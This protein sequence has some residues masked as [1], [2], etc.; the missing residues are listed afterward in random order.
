MKIYPKLSLADGADFTAPFSKTSL[1]KNDI[2]IFIGIGGAGIDML[3]ALKKQMREC[4]K[5]DYRVDDEP[6]YRNVRFLAVDTDPE[7]KK[8]FSDMEFFCLSK[9]DPGFLPKAMH[10]MPELSWMDLD[11]MPCPANM[12]KNASGCRAY[13]RAMFMLKSAS[14]FD[15][16]RQIV[17]ELYA[18]NPR[19]RM[20]FHIVSSLVGGTGSACLLD[21]C[22]LIRKALQV[23][24][25]ESTATLFGYL[26]LPDAFLC[27]LGIDSK[28][29]LA[30]GYAA[31]KE[32]DYFMQVDENGGQCSVMYQNGLYVDWDR[33]PL[34][35]CILFSGAD[36]SGAPAVNGYRTA[37]SAAVNTALCYLHP[38]ESFGTALISNLAAMST[39][40]YKIHGACT[41]YILVNC[42]A[43]TFPYG[44]ILA[45]LTAGIFRLLDPILSPKEMDH[46]P[47][48]FTKFLDTYL[49]ENLKSAAGTV[50]SYEY[51]AADA[52]SMGVEPLFDAYEY[53]FAD[54]CAKINGTAKALGNQWIER[55]RKLLTAMIYDPEYGPFTV[56]NLFAQ[57]EFSL[58]NR[59]DDRIVYLLAIEKQ[60]NERIDQ[61][62]E[63]IENKKAKLGRFRFGYHLRCLENLLQER[64]AM[65]MEL[66]TVMAELALLPELKERMTEYAN[67]LIFPLA[68]AC[69]RLQSTMLENTDAFRLVMDYEG[70]NMV[71]LSELMLLMEGDIQKIDV[72][73]A[74]MRFIDG[75]LKLNPTDD[76]AVS[77]YLPEFAAD[78]FCDAASLDLTRCLEVKYQ[79][80]QSAVLED[81][82]VKDLYAK[83]NEDA[84]LCG[85]AAG[86]ERIAGNKFEVMYLPNNRPIYA[87]GAVYKNV[88]AP[89]IYIS[90]IKVEHRIS[91]LRY[92]QLPLFALAIAEQ[93]EQ[94]YGRHPQLSP[95]ISHKGASGDFAAL[96]ELLPQRLADY[97][98]HPKIYAAG[99]EAKECLAFLK[100]HERMMHGFETD[101]YIDLPQKEE[102]AE[103]EKVMDAF[104]TEMIGMDDVSM[105][106]KWYEIADR[107]KALS[108]DRRIG[109]LN[110]HGADFR[111]DIAPFLADRLVYSPV[112]FSAIRYTKT[113]FDRYE[114]LK[115]RME[116]VEHKVQLCNAYLTAVISGAIS[117]N[118]LTVSAE[119]ENFGIT[120]EFVLS[121]PAMEFGRF[122]LY[123]GY[124]NFMK[125]KESTQA[126]IVERSHAMLTEDLVLSDTLRIWKSHSA[127][128]HLQVR[129]ENYPPQQREKILAFY[130][131]LTAALQIFY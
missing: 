72:K 32:L 76:D 122:P 12:S 4:I 68:K 54:Q 2:D 49:R 11:K 116:E 91:I 108:F 109:R 50:E 61:I 71:K 58:I 81:R 106:T 40:G 66:Q 82:L 63:A 120:K 118:G 99:I 114:S 121:T 27:R 103:L 88:H 79:T 69:E 95:H 83:L 47:P 35:C 92:Q 126:Q 22:Y 74:Y 131:S 86:L 26:L 16:I 110:C 42:A 46:L 111:N 55:L 101:N 14:F 123:Q 113:I 107:M 7:S 10:T 8:Y 21:V 125:L 129:T 18:Q 23:S 53:Q 77:A 94:A 112:L 45:Y 127:R 36:E 62:T 60:L 15:K 105:Q 38:S 93:A 73:D 19:V 75:M 80:D 48:Q 100:E 84:Q 1:E 28:V 90:N 13:G 65:R 96:P 67:T 29:V 89:R 5:A 117:V 98:K 97:E 44:N 56:A 31:M 57:S 78:I 37:R 124:V 17:C 9:I 119:T 115:Q 41:K 24:F 85:I 6:K 43:L 30:N 20:R 25:P 104:E 128:M 64:T 34:D 51:L 130:R 33:A 59:M 87:A 39:Y 70:D 102:L 3:A 52:K